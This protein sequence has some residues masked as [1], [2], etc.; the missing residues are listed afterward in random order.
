MTFSVLSDISIETPE[1]PVILKQGQ[2]IRLVE[3]E[4]MPL[5]EAGVIM[6]SVSSWLERLSD[7]ERDIFHERSAI[8]EYSGGLPREHAE[9]LAIQR[10]IQKR[11][12]PGKCNK[13]FKVAGC[14]MLPAH[15]LLCEVVKL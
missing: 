10:I 9:V 15:R 3:A 14:M 11:I 2:G 13:C 1:G 7:D 12:I 8:M 6:R 4:A 5:L